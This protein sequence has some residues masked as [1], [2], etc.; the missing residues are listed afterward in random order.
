MRRSFL[1]AALLL[2]PAAAL[3]Q[4]LPAAST[5]PTGAR[6]AIYVELFGNG[7]VAS[8][9]YGRT[10]APHLELRAGWG[11]WSTEESTDFNAL[12]KKFNVFPIMLQNVRGQ[13][14]HH[15]ELGLGL[16]LGRLSEEYG[17][18]TGTETTTT[19]IGDVE[20]LIGYRRQR[21]RGGFV[22]RAGLTPEYAFAGDYPSDGAFLS[23]GLSFGW[24][25]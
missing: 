15:L 18:T 19:T 20:G 11:E 8:I 10:I 12:R 17:T 3:A 6:N 1:L 24:A 22:F 21:P 2:A 9:N 25:F 23:A 5:G 4:Q 16:L 14:T 13:G 7:G